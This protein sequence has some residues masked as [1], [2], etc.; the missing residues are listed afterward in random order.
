MSLMKKVSII[1]GVVY[2]LLASLSYMFSWLKPIVLPVWFAPGFLTCQGVSSCLNISSSGGKGE[3]INGILIFGV[4]H[5]IGLL[6]FIL[7][8]VVLTVIF[9]KILHSPN[10][11]LS[12][13]LV[14]LFCF[15][16]FFPKEIGNGG[17]GPLPT[18]VNKCFG[19][20]RP[21]PVVMDTTVTICYG[22]PYQTDTSR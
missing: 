8:A 5:L 16:F 10:Q 12:L 15:V 7:A 1:F 17:F 13:L 11:T 21:G 9:S 14:V 19:V 22:I 6:I 20:S 3:A 18:V 2:I 4:F